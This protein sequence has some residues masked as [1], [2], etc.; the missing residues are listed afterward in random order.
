MVY[1]E[2]CLAS[3]E[4]AANKKAPQPTINIDGAYLSFCRYNPK[5]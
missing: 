2:Y 4:F 3:V 1:I 5:R